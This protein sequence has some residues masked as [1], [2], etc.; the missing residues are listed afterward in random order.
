M[1]Y[2]DLQGYVGVDIGGQ[3]IKVGTYEGE[4]LVVIDIPI[5]DTYEASKK[6][7]VAAA[8]ELLG[9]TP[10]GVGIGSPGP[11]DWRTGYVKFTP[12]IPWAR[13][14]HYLE[15]ADDLGC[16]VWVDNDANVA[17][18]AEACMGAGEGL[19]YVTGFTLGTG[20]G[21]FF[22]NNGRIYHGRYDVEG[23]HQIINPDGPLCGC[24]GKG[25][26]EAYISATAIERDTGMK[27]AD[28]N[29]PAF[30]DRYA[31][32]LAQAIM[33]TN[34]ILCPDIVILGGGIIKRGDMLMQPLEKHIKSME[35]ILPSPL[36]RVAKL[37][38]RAGV[39]GAIILGK[40]GHQ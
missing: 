5:P 13:E 8:H 25:H 14:I 33:T 24:S 4:E 40:Y 9:G 29:D 30:W 32:I 16:P 10:L 11:L 22:V 35:D 39:V 12:N 28:I 23:G 7:T 19:A 3:S 34:S 20:I 18:L 17:G 21:F 31:R 2:T 1:D 37:G 6:A 15:M 36:V 26:L 27:P 38:H